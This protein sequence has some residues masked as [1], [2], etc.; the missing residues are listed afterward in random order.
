MVESLNNEDENKDI[1]DLDED[2]VDTNA[3][4]NNDDNDVVVTRA[5]LRTRTD[6][7]MSFQSHG[8]QDGHFQRVYGVKHEVFSK[9]VILESVPFCPRHISKEKLLSI[10]T[11][12]IRLDHK[13]RF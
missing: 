12:D 8:Q 7:A 2:F 13:T 1:T 6:C 5:K 11:E 10:F 9:S 3:V 4:D